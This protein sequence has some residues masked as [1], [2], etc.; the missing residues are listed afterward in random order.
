MRQLV[1]SPSAGRS[2]ENIKADAV[3]P[4][5]TNPSAIRRPAGIQ[6]ICLGREASHN[7]EFGTIRRTGHKLYALLRQPEECKPPI[8]LVYV[9]AS[10]AVDDPPRCAAERRDLP[11][12]TLD[13]P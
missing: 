1:G 12:A 7:F 5:K 2:H 13:G 10:R 9:C 11:N 3:S 6:V 8:R 4:L